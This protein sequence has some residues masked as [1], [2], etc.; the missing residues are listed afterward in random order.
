VIWRCVCGMSLK[1]GAVH[2]NCPGVPVAHTDHPLRH[3]DRT[4]PACNPSGVT[5]AA[6]MK[7]QCKLC[8]ALVQVGKACFESGCPDGVAPSDDA[9]ALSDAVNEID[10]LNRLLEA[11]GDYA[12]DHSTGP[13]VPDAL[14]EVRRMAYEGETTDGAP[15]THPTDGERDLAA[16]CVRLV[17]RLREVS[18]DD[19]LGAT[20]TDYLNQRRYLNP[21]RIKAMG[22][23]PADGVPVT[24]KNQET[25]NG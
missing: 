15:V 7:A 1:G 22:P 20:A 24:P 25:T 18:P 11:I 6:P 4:C 16:L 10:R 3:H 2:L 5:Q 19:K 8:L 13:A 23:A 21:L 17:R 12:H 9:K 14:W